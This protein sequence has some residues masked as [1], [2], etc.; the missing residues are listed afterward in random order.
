M[1]SHKTTYQ[2]NSESKDNKESDLNS[3]SLEKENE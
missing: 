2:W 1:A 3:N